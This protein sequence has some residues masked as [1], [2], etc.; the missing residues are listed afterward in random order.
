VSTSPLPSTVTV[1]YGDNRLEIAERLEAARKA[2]DPTGLSTSIFDQAAS[3]IPEVASAIGSP[4]FFGAD[5]LVICHYLVTPSSS[6][7]RKKSS[8]SDGEGDPLSIL[9]AIA[10]GVRVVVVE[11][12]LKSV[13]EKRIRTYAQDVSVEHVQV[14]RGRAI[15][16]WACERARKHQS[17]MEGATATRLV[18][19][20]F[21]GSWRQAARRDDVPPDLQRLDTEIAKLAVS[22]GRGTEITGALV[23]ELVPNADALDVWGLTNAIADRDQAKAI[24]QLELALDAGQPPEVLLGQLAAQFETFAVVV[25]SKGRPNVL[26]AQRTGLSEG[27]LRQ[28]SRSARNYSRSELTRALREIRDTDFGIKQG[29][30]EPEDALAT[31]VA[32]LALR[33]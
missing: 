8:N 22:A 16:D 25:A 4:G 13:D 11:E 6:T 17:T 27:R 24:K 29:Y 32:G 5:R 21:P 31:L 30:F 26:I 33:R 28:A 2:I 20:L 3:A 9:G 7:R 15:I 18:E 23:A 12:S 10:P 14:P 19:A 1:L